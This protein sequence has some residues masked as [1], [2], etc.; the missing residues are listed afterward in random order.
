MW[1]NRGVFGA[2]TKRPPQPVSLAYAQAIRHGQV[3]RSLILSL[4]ASLAMVPVYF[5]AG[6]LLDG[7]LLGEG[8]VSAGSWVL[9]GIGLLGAV[10]G[11]FWAVI[12]GQKAQGKLETEL[13]IAVSEN[14]AERAAVDTQERSTGADLSTATDAVERVAAYR[15]TFL[16]SIIGSMLA[17]VLIAAAVAMFLDARSGLWL[18]LGVP[19]VPFLI[20][21][22]QSAFRRV[23]SKY[24]V[25]SRALSA[26]YLDSIQGLSELRTYGSD[27]Q[28]QQE[29]DRRSEGVRQRVMA[30]LAGNQLIVGVGD[31]TFSLAM[32]VLGGYL[33]LAGLDSGVLTVGGALTLVLLANAMTEPLDKVGQFFYIGMGGIAA[34]REVRAQLSL[35]DDAPAAPSTQPAVGLLTPPG[36]VV[37]QGVGF[38][39]GPDLPPVLE[40]FNLTVRPGERIGL[41]GP[42][43]V[44]KTTVLELLLGTRQTQSGTVLVNGIN[45][46]QAGP[47]G[48]AGEVAAVRQLPQLFSGSVAYNLRVAQP[49]ART[50]ELWQVLD[51]VGLREEVEALPDALDTEVGERGLHLSGGQAQRLALARALLSGAPVLVLDEPTAQVDLAGEAKVVRAIANLPADRT[52]IT[53]AHRATA[54]VGTTRTVELAAIPVAEAEVDNV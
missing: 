22:F 37:L 19:L 53:I 35:P 47:A 10:V 3:P 34:T 5:A 1:Q 33:A 26:Y 15:A 14:L 39:Y 21:G 17:P 13:R 31:L 12:S 45:P 27:G 18:L 9:I 44:G 30:M 16:G 11:N 46:G 54:L 6:Q 2:R 38:R 42:S 28:Q 36:S 24:R 49:E 40:D 48:M 52:V 23:S 41:V 7:L 8:I 20:G 4:I 32:L 25:S 51:Q 43:G 29:L 50:D